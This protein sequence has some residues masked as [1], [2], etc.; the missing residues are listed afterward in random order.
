VATASVI[1]PGNGQRFEVPPLKFR[2]STSRDRDDDG[3]HDEGET[4]LGTIN[5]RANPQ[6]KDLMA[7][8]SPMR[9]SCCR[10]S[11]PSMA[12]LFGRV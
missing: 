10:V 3:L 1:T 5:D 9:P 7:T 4:I 8:A 12:L 6:T 2:I 11:I